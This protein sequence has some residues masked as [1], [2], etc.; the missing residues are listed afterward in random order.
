MLCQRCFQENFVLK[1]CISCLWVSSCFI[2]VC[3]SFS[4]SSDLNKSLREW[5]YKVLIVICCWFLQPYPPLCDVKGS[6]VA[7]FEH[8]ILLRPTCKEVI[9]RGDDYWIVLRLLLRLHMLPSLQCHSNQHSISCIRSS[10]KWWWHM[11]PCSNWTVSVTLLMLESLEYIFWA[12]YSP[13]HLYVA[14]VWLIQ[15]MRTSVA[16]DHEKICQVSLDGR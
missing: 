10:H 7:Q 11:K 2:S 3:L 5:K 6:Y 15:V 14:V 8:T 1:F 9:S 12:Q 13:L 4:F 16:C